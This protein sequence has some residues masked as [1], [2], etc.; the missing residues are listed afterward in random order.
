[1]HDLVWTYG[2]FMPITCTFGIFGNLLTLYVMLANGKK[3]NG[4][5]FL[6]MKG[7]AIIDILQI[8]HTIQ[9]CTAEKSSQICDLKENYFAL[10]TY[11]FLCKHF[12]ACIYIPPVDLYL[13]F[14][15]SS[16]KNQVR[17]T[18]FLAYKNQ[19]PSCRLHRQ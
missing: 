6:Y 7:L 2:I 1:M 4:S 18:G 8:I 19:F 11:F 15:Q 13:N 16:W 3:F 10:C 17:R 14:E 5:I 9:V 12:F